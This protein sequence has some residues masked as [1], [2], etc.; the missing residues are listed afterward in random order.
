[1]WLERGGTATGAR[2]GLK[3]EIVGRLGVLLVTAV[4]GT[5]RLGPCDC[6]RAA[7]ITI[8]KGDHCSPHCHR[9]VD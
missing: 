6:W 8:T 3:L 5:L 9:G 2:K 4:G 7:L 1:M